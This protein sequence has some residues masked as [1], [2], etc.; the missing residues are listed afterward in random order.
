MD[1][2]LVYSA[3][4]DA[5]V[6]KG[7][8][9]YYR[10]E[11]PMRTLHKLGYAEC[12]LDD[13]NRIKEEESLQ[14]LFSSDI[15]IIYALAGEAM[16]RV[17]SQ[18]EELK[19]GLAL[20]E[21][22]M[23]YP[24]S[25]VFD[26][27][28]NISYVHPM[29]F[30]Y[31]IY[32]TR[33]PDGQRLKI[34]DTVAVMLEDGREINLWTDKVTKAEGVVFDIERNI[35]FVEVLNTLAAKCQ[36]AT[37]PSKH[38]GKWFEDNYGVK[39]W[40]FFPNSVIPEDYPQVEL[41]PHKGVR[42][43]WQGGMSH[44]IDWDAVIMGAIKVFQ[45]HPQAKMV[46]WGVDIFPLKKA[47]EE[48]GQ[49]EHH[50]WMDYGAYKPYRVMMDCDINLCPL[51]DNMFNQCKSAIKWYEASMLLKPEATLAANVPPYSDEIIDGE[52][53]LLYDNEA[54]F[55]DKL[56]KLIRSRELRLKLATNAKKWVL[57]NRLADKTCEDLYQYY[58]HLREKRVGQFAGTQVVPVGA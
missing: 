28:D 1:K 57:E 36:G 42:V 38:L 26:L 16:H 54:E 55:V 29:N 34:G 58:Q 12:F 6:K 47:L 21:K 13:G 9:Q 4:K 8:G 32:G 10:V 30:T 49:Y 45:D 23:R 56:G 22:T 35:K 5:R 2:L 50:Q 24:P 7:A 44:A 39:D 48:R 53:G 19:P 18:I 37:F 31:N 33:S 25:P 15:Y 11:V 14:N 40:H 20:D 51:V 52:T 3:I 43:L 17:V 46:T 27:D 41:V